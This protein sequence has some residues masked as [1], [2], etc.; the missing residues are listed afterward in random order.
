MNNFL[1]INVKINGAI[2]SGHKTK[3]QKMSN[4]DPTKNQG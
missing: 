4:M 2:K 3:T 1:Q